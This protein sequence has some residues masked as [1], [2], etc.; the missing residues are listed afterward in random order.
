MS[1]Y[2]KEL[3]KTCFVKTNDT[4]SYSPEWLKPIYYIEL[5]DGR[6]II[7]KERENG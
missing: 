2:P 6:A 4:S 3:I 5:S 1:D 7:I